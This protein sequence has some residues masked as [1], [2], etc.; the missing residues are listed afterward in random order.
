MIKKLAKHGNGRALTLDKSLLDLL[1]IT[2]DTLLKITTDGKGLNIY[3]VD[4]ERERKFQEAKENSL[5]TQAKTIKA[6]A[7]M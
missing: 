1:N 5:K 7:D 4:P 2:D 3:P 6:L